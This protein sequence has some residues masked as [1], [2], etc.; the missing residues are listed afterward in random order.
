MIAAFADSGKRFASCPC[1]TVKIPH[2]GH[3]PSLSPPEW[4]III[5]L[6][7]PVIGSRAD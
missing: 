7:P 5:L 3:N 2:F 1:I 4:G 6:L